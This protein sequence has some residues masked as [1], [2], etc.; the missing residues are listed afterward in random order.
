MVKLGEL[1][2]KK[3]KLMESTTDNI[4]KMMSFM[5]FFDI[6]SLEERNPRIYKRIVNKN[7]NCDGKC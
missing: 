7:E 3:V 1:D 5:G 6:H 2:K 4:Y